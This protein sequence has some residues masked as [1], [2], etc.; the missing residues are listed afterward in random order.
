MRKG[1]PQEVASQTMVATRFGVERCLRYAFDLATTRPRRHLTLVHKTNVLTFAGETWHRAF[2]Q[3]A[4]DYPDVETAY[5]HVDACCMYMVTR[6]E[7]YDVIVVPNMFGDIITDLGAAIAG[8]MGIASSGNLNP[9]GAAPGMFEPVHGS[10]PDIAG[11]NQA[12]PIATIDSLGLLLREDG[13][14]HRGQGRGRRGRTDRRRGQGDHT[15]LRGEVAR[16]QRLHHGP[17]RPDGDRRAM[18]WA[19]QTA[20]H[21]QRRDQR[22]DERQ[23]ENPP[24][25]A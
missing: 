10:A 2:K 22:A 20:A 24:T 18:R 13:P 16:P 14:H 7:A 25:D 1:T 5:H 6:P 17:S 15:P 9:E 4:E 23:A 11:K 12:N 3:V 8:G 21:P 19:R